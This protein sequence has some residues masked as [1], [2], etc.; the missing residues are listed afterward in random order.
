MKKDYEIKGVFE[1]GEGLNLHIHCKITFHTNHAWNT[2]CKSVIGSLN[3]NIGFTKIKQHINDGWDK[4]MAK[5]KQAM[6]D[7][8]IKE[9]DTADVRSRSV[10]I[11]KIKKKKTHDL[12]PAFKNTIIDWARQIVEADEAKIKC[13]VMDLTP[14]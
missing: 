1:M 4:Y 14:Q 7:L 9:F 6:A 11:I 2:F 5:E 3:H 12:K 8:G 13:K 10:Q